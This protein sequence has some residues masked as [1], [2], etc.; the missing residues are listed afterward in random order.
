MTFVRGLP[1]SVPPGDAAI[2]HVDQTFV[3]SEYI[4]LCQSYPISL[5]VIPDISK[6]HISGAAIAEGED[7]QGRVI[8]KS[9]F[10]SFGFPER[11][12][13]G[14]AA[15]RGKALPLPGLQFA[16]QYTVF[17]KLQDVP[18]SILENSAQVVEKF[19]P[20]IE[21][22]G[23]ATRFWTFCGDQER[24]TKYVSPDALVKGSTAIRHEPSP[25]PD[26]IRQR[27][28]EL[29][30]D[31]GKFDFVIHEGKPIL[32]DTNKTPGRPPERS[33]YA[34]RDTLNLADGFES[35][36]RSKAS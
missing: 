33:N 27:R 19:L 31:F 7:W 12:Q 16:K 23:Y 28:R 3:A 22:D 15:R 25:V 35:L 18:Q 9:N 34:S 14:I 2:L 6:R 10:N 20:E 5:N 17:E 11:R 4:E 36:L 8:V 29:G 30:F 13:N 1:D 26:E 21:P 24:C 32:L